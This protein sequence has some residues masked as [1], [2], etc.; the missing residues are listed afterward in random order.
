MHRYMVEF[1]FIENG[2]KCHV[3]YLGPSARSEAEAVKTAREWYGFDKDNIEVV[4]T[5]V[6]KED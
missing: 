3:A 1:D 6:T 5:T 2:R 4:K